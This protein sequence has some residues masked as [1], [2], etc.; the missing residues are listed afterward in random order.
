HRPRPRRDPDHQRTGPAEGSREAE[1]VT[2]ALYVLYE[3]S[4]RRAQRRSN[5]FFLCGLMDCF[6]AH[7]FNHCCLWNTGSVVSSD[8]QV[9]LTAKSPTISDNIPARFPMRPFV[10]IWPSAR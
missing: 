3:P 2:A 4:L 7:R 5:P 9:H 6:A 8:F 10:G 1:G